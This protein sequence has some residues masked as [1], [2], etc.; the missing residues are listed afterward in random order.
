[1]S[2][3]D[4]SA[5]KGSVEKTQVEAAMESVKCGFAAN[6]KII[7]G[8]LVVIIIVLNTFWNMTETKISET[9]AQA[10]GSITVA[11][12][13]AKEMESLKTEFKSDIAK[14]DARLSEAEKGTIDLDAVKADIVAIKKAGEDFEKKLNAVIKAEEGKL[15]LLEQD[16]AN[17]KAYIDELK[18]LLEEAAK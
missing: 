9:V 6:W 15:A 1:M 7:A 10:I 16:A 3:R 14:L 13:V 4:K 17:Q 8:I 12:E 5:K 18:S 2:D 11:E